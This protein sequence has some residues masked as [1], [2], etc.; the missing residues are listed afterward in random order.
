VFVLIASLTVRPE[1]IDEFR[2]VI[3][4]NAAASVRYER[5]CS[6]FDV[7]ELDGG[8]HRFVLYESY[9]DA[10]AFDAHKQTEHFR[11]WRR[12]ADRALSE[13]VNRFGTLIVSEAAS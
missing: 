10:A 5:G 3:A 11:A 1:A 4:A 2:S 6:R 8:E 7:V 13:Q 12:V 9:D